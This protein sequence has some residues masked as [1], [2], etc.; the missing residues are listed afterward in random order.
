[1]VEYCRF[2]GRMVGD[3][4]CDASFLVSFLVA[5]RCCISFSNKKA[6]H[7]AWVTGADV[8]QF[9]QCGGVRAR[10]MI[11]VPTVGTKTIW[12]STIFFGVAIF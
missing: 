3:T 6:G 4:S 11:R 5:Q 2:W 9:T 12:V 10:V 8:L 7:V 1:M